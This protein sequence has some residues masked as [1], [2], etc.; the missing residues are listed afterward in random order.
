MHT[1]MLLCRLADP[2]ADVRCAT[3]GCLGRAP[4][5]LAPP[6]C[7]LRGDHPPAYT[8]TLLDAALGQRIPQVLRAAEA[9]VRQAAVEA[10]AAML[11]AALRALGETPAAEKPPLPLPYLS[12]MA[13]LL[14][15]PLAD[16]DEDVR[17]A[18]LE[19]LD[20]CLYGV[21]GGAA[22]EQPE[23]QPGGGFKGEP[24][25]GEPA[26]AAAAELRDSS[27]PPAERGAEV[28]SG[29]G[30]ERST[31]LAAG[32]SAVRARVEADA[33]ALSRHADSDA[34]HAAVTLLGY[35]FAANAEVLDGGDEAGRG[36]GREAG[37]GARGKAEGGDEVKGEAGDRVGAAQPAGGR[38]GGGAVAAV[39]AA[40]E[41]IEWDVRHA[42]LTALARLPAHALAVHAARLLDLLEDPSAEVRAAALDAIEEL[43]AATLTP[44]A[45][46]RRVTELLEHQYSGVRTDAV[47]AVGVLAAAA[48]PR[49]S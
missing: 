12:T 2:D 37:R 1:R 13:A 34:R 20:R 15:E 8:H 32:L 40:L 19:A 23:V 45:T 44:L 31:R 3:L 33:V 48:W 10:L 42:G 35:A 14:L 46:A 29:R 26:A 30:G 39:L 18:A 25:E 22:A 21:Y 27:L 6:A 11:R 16:E 43:P 24:A 47:R 7:A 4:A 28:P 36:A 38:D 17:Q 5:L 49:P 9:E 41:D